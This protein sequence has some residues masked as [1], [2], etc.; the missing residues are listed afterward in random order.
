MDFPI[1]DPILI[2]S[3]SMAMVLVAPLLSEKLKIPSIIGLISA[4]MIVGPN[5][6][7]ILERDQSIE[8]L[9][10]IGLLYI[11]FQAGLEIDIEQLRRDKHHTILFGLFTFIIPLIMGTSAAYYTLG[12]SLVASILLSSMFSSH[13][14]LTFPIVSRLGLS[15]KR[16]V[17]TAVGGTIVTDTLA[18]LVL[19]VIIAAH[20]GNVCTLFWIRLFLS[21]GIYSS[22]TIWILPKAGSWFFRHFTSETGVEEFVFIFTAMFISAFFSH[23]AGLE[24][25]IGAFLAGLTLN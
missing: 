21:I 9:G 13:T 8:L 3:I 17:T 10:T 5:L 20:H 14:L 6:A 11:M 1:T 22:L 4:G 19:A 2:F 12:L 18:L 25:I 23:I 16:S 15:K 24:P 7:G